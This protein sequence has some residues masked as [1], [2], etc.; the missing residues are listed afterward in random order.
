MALYSGE[1]VSFHGGRGTKAGIDMRSI[2]YTAGERIF[3]LDE[4][5][6]AA[7]GTGA[8]T[9][10]VAG[11]SL[12]S[13]TWGGSDASG[14]V[15]L[16]NQ[17]GTLAAGV[18][19]AS[20]PTK[21]CDIAGDTTKQLIGGSARTWINNRGTDFV[22]SDIMGTNGEEV[23]GSKGP[24]NITTS[25]GGSPKVLITLDAPI[26]NA[27]NMLV[28]VAFAG[29][30]G[31]GSGVYEITASTS[32]PDTITIDLAYTANETCYIWVGGAYPGTAAGLQFVADN[33]SAATSNQY[34]LT[35]ADLTLSAALDFDTGGGSTTKNTHKHIIGFRTTPPNN[36][37]MDNGDMDVGGSRYGG[38]MDALRDEQS[39]TLENANA[40]WVDWNAEANNITVA[41]ID[42]DNYLFRNIR[43]RGSNPSSKGFVFANTPL[44]PCLQ[45]CRI[46]IGNLPVDGSVTYSEFSDSY[47]R[48]GYAYNFYH[49]N[50]YGFLNNCVFDGTDAAIACAG[51]WG[52]AYYN[53]LFYGTQWGMRIISSS[54]AA[55]NNLFYGQSATAFY[56]AHATNVNLRG[57][58]NIIMTDATS[59]YAID[60]HSNGGSVSPD[61]GY[62]CISDVNGTALTDWMR[63]GTSGGVV[64]QLDSHSI[65]QNPLLKD[66]AAGQ[67]K[68]LPTSPALNTGK[69]TLD[70][71]KTS[72][73]P[74]QR[75]QYPIRIKEDGTI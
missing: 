13:G 30:A 44:M 68:L 61:F 25:G 8:K 40:D 37:N 18:L 60:V 10:N 41:N 14:T 38:A 4:Q 36:A 43:L 35:N 75:K 39:W 20:G 48:G 45:N 49:S 52:C 6:T 59:D 5:V 64:S 32:S 51:S 23:N 19:N 9:A 2:A 27:D 71:G 62:N 28:Y 34:I 54:I 47:F 66:I 58:G 11:W 74:W 67:I 29:T 69:P 12:T 17:S 56:L 1:R 33:M 21:V 15:W 31:Y 70:D 50:A 24:F 72:I 53:C 73:G 63:H 7:A 55:V 46:S 57:F 3:V 26:T 16:Y 65:E 42:G 22:L